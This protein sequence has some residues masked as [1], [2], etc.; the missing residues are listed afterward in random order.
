MRWPRGFTGSCRRTAPPRARPSRAVGPV[1][2][3]AAVPAVLRLAQLPNIVVARAAVPDMA[4]AGSRRDRPRRVPINR[5]WCRSRTPPHGLDQRTRDLS[6]TRAAHVPFP[7]IN[8]PDRPRT[9]LMITR[10]GWNG[11]TARCA[12]TRQRRTRP[13]QAWAMSGTAAHPATIF[14][15]CTNPAT[16]PTRG[17]EGNRADR[18]EDPEPGHGAVASSRERRAHRRFHDHI[19]VSGVRSSPNPAQVYLIMH[20][21]FRTAMIAPRSTTWRREP[22]RATRTQPR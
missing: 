14:G 1:P 13:Q 2:W 6:R 17:V 10:Q 18:A 21:T 9:G 16:S 7:P 8:G 3:P 5:R 11:T 20:R 4:Q 15:S 19:D 22:L 12:P